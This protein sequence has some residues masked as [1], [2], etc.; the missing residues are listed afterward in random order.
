MHALSVSKCS[1]PVLEGQAQIVSAR[2]NFKTGFIAGDAARFAAPGIDL[3]AEGDISAGAVAARTA[4]ATVAGGAVAELGGGK[5]A[6]G[7]ATG[8]MSRFFNDEMHPRAWAQQRS[9]SRGPGL[10]MTGHKVG[11]R[12]PAHLAI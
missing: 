8:A 6:N 7:A 3:I 12:G 11:G 5:F 9:S 2:G 10:H 4:E 1:F